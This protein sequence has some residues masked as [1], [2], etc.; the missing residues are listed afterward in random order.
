M[1]KKQVRSELEINVLNRITL[2]IL[3]SSTVQAMYIHM[4]MGPH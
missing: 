3:F 4:L 1:S 2:R